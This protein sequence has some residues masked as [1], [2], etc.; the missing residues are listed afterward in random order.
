MVNHK[1]KRSAG[2]RRDRVERRAG[3]PFRIFS[4]GSLLR[5]PRVAGTV[6]RPAPLRGQRRAPPNDIR[7]RLHDTM[8]LAP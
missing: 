6:V 7:A 1:E 8:T 4:R 3:T 5:A 2:G